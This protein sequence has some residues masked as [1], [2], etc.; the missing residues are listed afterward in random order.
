MSVAGPI[1]QEDRSQ[2]RIILPWSSS[3]ANASPRPLLRR[4]RPSSLRAPLLPA[5]VGNALA[6]PPLYRWTI[7]PDSTCFPECHWKRGDIR[8][9]IV[10]AI[11]PV[12][13]RVPFRSRYVQQT[14]CLAVRHRAV[15]IEDRSE[16][17]SRSR[18]R[19]SCPPHPY[20]CRCAGGPVVGTRRCTRI[21]SP[22][23]RFQGRRGRS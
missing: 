12:R 13:R 9:N 17:A 7:A 20:R 10:K 14:N 8:P 11:G 1:S 5:G 23:C 6:R 3:L 2:K 18:D 15:S 16:N 19:G 4:R 21:P 22:R